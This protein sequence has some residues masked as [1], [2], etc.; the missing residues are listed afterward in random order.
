MA[1]RTAR[2]CS[3]GLPTG[4]SSRVAWVSSVSAFRFYRIEGA[5]LLSSQGGEA[6]TVPVARWS[7][8]PGRG[9]E[10]AAAAGMP[11]NDSSTITAR[12]G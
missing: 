5:A 12:S 2:R 4:S 3:T 9:R 1:T 6:A 8:G 7:P 11:C 10:G